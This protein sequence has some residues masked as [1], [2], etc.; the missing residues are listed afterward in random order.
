MSGAVALGLAV[1]AAT[2]VGEAGAAVAVAPEYQVVAEAPAQAPSY[3]P[4]EASDEASA[5]LM[6]RLQ[7]QRIEVLNERTADSSTFVEADG[8]LTTEAYAGP[9]RVKQGD[10][11]WKDVDTA[12]TDAGSALK[13]RAAVADV[14]VSDGG[15][16]D[17]AS[18]SDGSRTFGLQ[19][20][21][22]LPAPRVDGSTA[23]YD[24]GGGASLTVQA[25]AQGFEQ[26]VVLAQAPT[27]PVSYRI[28]L[29][30]KGLS[31]SKDA[32]TGHLLLKD[33]AGTVVAEAAAPHMWDA[34][35][36]PVSGE[37][38]H[39][40]EV[41]TS[42]E[43][44]SDGSTTLVLT[45][46]PAFFAQDLTYPVTIDPSSTL[47][48]TTDTWVQTPDYP[49]SQLGSQELKAG[50][51]DTGTDV[52]RSYVK[53]DV[54]KFAGKHILGATMSLYSY[55]SATC[56][57]TG[58]GTQAKRV[59][60][61]LDTTT[62]TWGAQPSTTTTNMYTN[63]GHWGYDAS[64]PANWSNWTLT[65]MVQDWANGAANYGI[66][67][68]SADETDPTTWRR[69]RSANY[70]TPGYAPKLVV[71]YNSHPSQATLVSPATGTAT[72]DTTP[73]LQAK[74]TDPDGDKLTYHFEIWNSAG[75]TMIASGDSPQ[76]SSGTTGSWTAP[77]LAQGSYKW[78][79]LAR[80]GTDGSTT[81][82]AWNTFTVDT[83]APATTSIVAPAFPAGAWSGT[84]DGNGNLSG[85]FTFTPPASGL[86]G[87]VYKLDTGSWTTAATTGTAVTKTLTFK[88]GW[89]TVKVHS[90]DAAGNT[91]ADT[92]YSFGAGQASLASPVTGDVTDD[93]VTLSGQQ[94][95]GFTGVT[96][97][98][99]VGDLGTWQPVPPADVRTSDG[100]AVAA[101]PLTFASSQQPD[102]LTWAAATTFTDDGSL[103]VRAV[104]TNGSTT[105]TTPAATFTIN[106]KADNAPSSDIGPGSVNLLTGDFTLSA[107]DASVFGVSV[108]RS[109]SSRYPL[110]GADQSGHLAIFGPNWVS[111]IAGAPSDWSYVKPTSDSHAVNLVAAD[112]TE[113]GFT[114]ASSTSS[115]DL[116]TP[117]P[118]AESLT[119]TDTR[120][121][122]VV[123]SFALVTTDGERDTFTRTNTGQSTW[124]L[125]TSYTV[126][127]GPATA[128]T[129]VS[130][131]IRQADGVSYLAEPRYVI[132][133]TGAVSADQ[134]AAQPATKGC[135]VLEFDYGPATTATASA[136]GDFAGQVQQLRLWATDPG[137][138]AATS[139]VLATY[140]YDASGQLVSVTD[141]RSGLAT[142][143]SYD[144]AGHLR[145]LTPPGQLPWTFAYGQVGTGGDSGPGMLLSVSRP[146]LATGTTDTVDGTATTS[147]VYQVPVS[148][149]GAPY[150]LDSATTSTWDQ[151]D[152]PVSGTAII[153]P[154]G[155]PASHDGTQLT[156]AA[157]A[158]ATIDYSDANGRAV[159]T[160]GP[161][162]AI[163]T[164][165]YDTDGNVVRE[166][167][168]DNRALALGTTTSSDSLLAD[169]L[170]K[171]DGTAERAD[172][173][174][175]ETD[176]TVSASSGDEL[177]TGDYGPLHTVVL[178]HDLTGPL[179]MLPAGTSV[180]ARAH[181]VQNYDEGRP[182]DAA[183]SD[184]PTSR[185]SGA[186]VEGYPSD[187]DSL[188]TVS[189]YDW[190]TGNL[191]K[192]VDD[193]DG[194]DLTAAYTY[195]DNGNQLTETQPDQDATN[196]TDTLYWSA[197]GTGSC[198]GRPEWDGWI[199]QT[200]PAAPATGGAN[201]GELP[202]KSFTYD[203]YGNTISE[204]D[205][206]N[207]QTRTVTTAYDPAE[208][209][210]SVQVTST[211]GTALAE[212]DQ[213]Y[214]P[215]TGQVATQSN[216]TQTITKH[217]DA[218]GRQV[219]Y[220]DGNGNS[221]T[222][223]YDAQ[224]RP[225]TSADSAPGTTTWTYD[226][227]TGRTLSITDSVAGTFTATGYDAD[228]NL[229]GEKLPGGYT[230]TRTIDT[231]GQ[232][233]GRTY[234]DASG[235]VVLYDQ[236]DLAVTGQQTDH[237]ENNGTTLTTGFQYDVSGRLTRAQDDTGDSCTT[238]SYTF[239]SAARFDRTGL[240]TGRS[241]TD[242]ADATADT[243]TTTTVNH[244]YDSA[245]R[246]TDAGYT[247]DAFGNAV[248]APGASLAYYAN[249]L[250]R[251]ETT[252]TAKQIW[253]LDAAQRL[254]STDN[255]T[256]T[257]GGSTWT[258]QGT[259][260]NHYDGDSDSPAWT[261]DP[262]GGVTRYVDD[263]SGGLA[264]VTGSST[265]LQFANL[266]GDIATTVDLS[267]GAISA[268]FYDEFGNTANTSRFGW[269]GTAERRADTPTGLILM[270]VRLYDPL[271]GAFTS[272]DPV[273]G[274]SGNAYSYCSSDPVN[275]S[276][277]TGTY[278][279]S[280]NNNSTHAERKW[281]RW[282]SRWR[283][284]DIILSDAH[285][286]RSTA[287]RVFHVTLKSMGRSYADAFQHILWMTLLSWDIGPG[288]ALAAG[289]RHEDYPGNPSSAKKMAYHNNQ[290]GAD[291]G[292]WMKSTF[293]YSRHG[294]VFA[295]TVVQYALLYACYDSRVGVPKYIASQ[296][297]VCI[298]YGYY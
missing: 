269:L 74:A 212:A 44:G 265:S 285:A 171:A 148:G 121:G 46:D 219:S 187:G 82:P 208:R 72:R 106:R 35:K 114:L 227:T 188:R 197:T 216:G 224:D 117:E 24:M 262:S 238:R 146:T 205:T 251:S 252:A 164:T 140:L 133:P 119:L 162:G 17:L 295:N 58:P 108:A 286:A 190:D 83:L 293:H 239:A 234:T 161:G 131:E 22:M 78:R 40:H 271:A 274:G 160:A 130:N 101:W 258:D 180:A 107:T 116:W 71:N 195:D 90:V 77:A 56:A 170:A 257:D 283:V 89:H 28:P 6:A 13:P 53:F 8:S 178:T 201:P 209:E 218:L 159:N 206:A 229:L 157:Y 213:T 21:S 287:L 221:S 241:A 167:T 4:A 41:A 64:C 20:S 14:A 236:A 126:S 91:S 115:G 166:L 222:T 48:V 175:S 191:L 273:D 92:S 132:A 284:C 9:V 174:S 243:T 33:A 84:P 277:T 256:S 29:T 200:S 290:L 59:T 60:S 168:A 235:E 165:E 158:T 42:I 250:P 194:L 288:S 147:V 179:G 230:L 282:P 15:D 281:C 123:S 129:V 275:C 280:E 47:A 112:G 141:P 122:G 184:M 51:Y 57:T 70:T 242:C 135:R 85:S 296:Y 19:W 111:G 289:R 27:G 211:T 86:T 50:T 266:H 79:A 105:Y 7:G 69:F 52:A 268:A 240:S 291:I 99:R 150:P 248:T 173:L 128:T 276:D 149:D 73:T 220:T 185:T 155:E 68:R 223:G 297:K 88:A 225:V 231:D 189:V 2:V 247:Y 75:T 249:N 81:W 39:Q 142:A 163:T 11:S 267:S 261:Q 137:A 38:V 294:G 254:A 151:T 217:Y 103:Q 199:C 260:V 61:P 263:L 192:D 203:R 172:L 182:S 202:V 176:Y 145:T 66:Q 237:V 138:G 5:R 226:P 10:G 125:T 26:S 153:P 244:G 154:G 32:G 134:C 214:D 49:D 55:Y 43:T 245:D 109:A 102:D 143:Y 30:L 139:S 31:L 1:S 152:N 204:T 120:S 98:Y 183:V 298:R 100:G 193:P 87:V 255:Q 37:P 76:V 93:S 232:Q 259:T 65:G 264:A 25:L 181:T 94:D 198:Q 136:P 127:G 95:G 23:T 279:E 118:G 110:D 278:S 292:S 96:Y 207:G 233:T 156:A 12:L 36:D 253:Y 63:T 45:P 18:V 169:R 144:A 270:G 54:S 62:L 104:F 3:G 124:Q 113:T 228:G 67:V 80:D 16:K 186:A 215:S 246:F 196:T 210:K 97:Q 272:I 34:S 177:D